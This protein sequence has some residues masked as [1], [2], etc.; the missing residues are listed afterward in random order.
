[1]LMSEVK[2][3]KKIPTTDLSDLLMYIVFECNC[4]TT[5]PP[6]NFIGMISDTLILQQNK[7]KLGFT[8]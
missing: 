8:L 5:V 3:K 7:K 4:W 2:K 6:I 1:M